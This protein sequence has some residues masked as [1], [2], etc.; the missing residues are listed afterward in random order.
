MRVPKDTKGAEEVAGRQVDASCKVKLE[1]AGC[2]L[3]GREDGLEE[4][5]EGVV[6]HGKEG[7][8]SGCFVCVE[9]GVLVVLVV[10]D[11]DILNA[12]IIYDMPFRPRQRKPLCISSGPKHLD[13][14]ETRSKSS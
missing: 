11:A 13:A 4:S 5:E 14:V 6:V 1:A 12:G 10:F 2:L 9:C 7:G 8:C 3:D